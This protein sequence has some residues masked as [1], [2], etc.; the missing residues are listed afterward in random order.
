MRVIYPSSLGMLE[1]VTQVTMK[2]LMAMLNSCLEDSWPSTCTKSAEL[3]LSLLTFALIGVLTVI[4]L[5]IVYTRCPHC[6][7]CLP[8]LCTLRR[9]HAKHS[10]SATRS[11]PCAPPCDHVA[12]TM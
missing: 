12:G 11:H 9:I 8:G 1:G 3:W 4:W 7:R 5:K 6:I 10:H 2:M